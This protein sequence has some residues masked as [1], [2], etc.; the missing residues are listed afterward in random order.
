M[1][2]VVNSVSQ[3]FRKY[4]R[5]KVLIVEAIV[6]VVIIGSVVILLN[7]NRRPSSAPV[8]G[9]RRYTVDANALKLNGTVKSTQANSLTLNDGSRD[10]NINIA[11]RVPIFAI[12]LSGAALNLKANDMVVVR[13]DLNDKATLV[14]LMSQTD[15]QGALNPRASRMTIGVERYMALVNGDIDANYLDVYGV[16][17]KIGDGSIEVRDNFLN[18]LIT[19]NTSEAKFATATSIIA[20]EISVDSKATVYAREINNGL[21]AIYI[22]VA[23]Q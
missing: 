15:I 19:I 13:Y 6:V 5:R 11:P 18:K 17:T 12:K 20:Q 16:I 23:Q 8:A 4:G 3:L 21:D 1:K 10:N 7:I 9:G 22:T 2:K 14:T